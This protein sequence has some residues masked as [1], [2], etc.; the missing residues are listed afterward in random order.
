MINEETQKKIHYEDGTLQFPITYC[1]AWIID[2]QHRIY[3]F[4]DHPKYKNWDGENED[5]D[6]KIPVVAFIKLKEVEQNKTFVNINYY[7]K[8]IDPV[9]FNDLST[10]IKDLKQELTWPSLLVSDMNKHGPWKSMVKISELDEKKPITI[11]GFAKLKLL[12]T[13]LGFDKKTGSYKGVLYRISG[14][15]PHLPFS[16]NKN[17]AA[18]R[19][20]LAILNRF[21]Y[22]VRKKV[23]DLDPTKD[24]WLNQKEYGLT[25]FTCVNALLVVLNSLLEKDP[26]MK[27]GLSKYLSV[28]DEVNFQNEKLLKYGRGYPAIPKIANKIIRAMNSKYGAKL[29]TV[30]K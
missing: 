3:G 29:K 18:F 22:A 23:E 5:D 2:G 21:F 24:K 19:I 7:Q 17:Q 25:K 11:S 27:F 26:K 28:L 4:K 16:D 15:N 9:L 13:L 12:D 8:K 14:F 30:K 20:H 6:F 1:S 10:V